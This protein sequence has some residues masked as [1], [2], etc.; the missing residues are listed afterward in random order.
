MII[1]SISAYSQVSQY[2]SYVS[3]T[4]D[5]AG[6]R[7]RRHIVTLPIDELKTDTVKTEQNTDNGILEITVYPNPTQGEINISANQVLVSYKLISITGQILKSDNINSYSSQISLNEFA[8]GNYVVIL[9]TE[10][11]K[12]EFNIIKE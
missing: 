3:F 5:D 10:D 2:D 11:N 1:T 6:N 8:S 12:Q 4:Y 7:I 9:F